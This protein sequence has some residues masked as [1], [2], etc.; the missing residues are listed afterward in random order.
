MAI[1]VWVPTYGSSMTIQPEVLVIPPDQYGSD[2]ERRVQV[3]TQ[4]MRRVWSLS[5]ENRPS[6]TADAI[7]TFLAARGSLEAFDWTPPH[8]SAGKWVCDEWSSSPTSPSHRS[9]EATFREV[10]GE[11]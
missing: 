1:F 5:F 7:E 11:V 3:G 9:V 8:G 2:K 4:H 10:L 6:G